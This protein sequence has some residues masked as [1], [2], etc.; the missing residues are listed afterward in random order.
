M[1]GLFR[2]IEKT[3]D[4]VDACLVLGWLAML[5]AFFIVAGPEAIAPHVERYGICLIGPGALI[6]ARGLGWWVEQAEPHG[7]RW[8]VVLAVAAWLWPA[9]FAVNYFQCFLATGGLSHYAF[10]TAAVEPKQA[11]LQYV[12]ED[13]GGPTGRFG[14]SATNGGTIGRRLTWRFENLACRS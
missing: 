9:S 7:R 14:S 3:P 8:A 10:R 4:A 12:L 1:W 5:V 2:R 13:T 6:V 11:A